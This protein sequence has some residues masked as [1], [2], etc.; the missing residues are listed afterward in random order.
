[1]T[2][3]RAELIKLRRSKLVWV[4]G[5]LCALFDVFL[6]AIYT[7]NGSS[8]FEPELL[9]LGQLAALFL[10]SFIA[11]ANVIPAV[12]IGGYVGAQDY[13]DRVAGSAVHWGGRYQSLAGKVVATVLALCTLVVATALFGLLLGLAHDTNLAH[14]DL[15]RLLHQTGLGMLATAMLGLFALTVATLV[16]SLALANLITVVTLFGQMFLPP[17][18]GQVTRFVN[19]LA[20]LGDAAESAFST[21][22]GL[23]NFSTSFGNGLSLGQSVIGLVVYVFCCLAALCLVARFREYR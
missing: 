12:L 21:L 13:G 6:F 23:R 2:L 20:C 19:P 11:I 4:V 14:L 3:I 8:V 10:C 15:L 7:A 5:G 16:R 17:R 18:L 9:P 22:D 1:M